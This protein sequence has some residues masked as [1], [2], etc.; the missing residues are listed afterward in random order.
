MLWQEIFCS[1]SHDVAFLAML[2][3]LNFAEQTHQ[4]WDLSAR[5]C[6]GFNRGVVLREP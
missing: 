3:Q 2:A 1:L 5:L 4:K 6:G